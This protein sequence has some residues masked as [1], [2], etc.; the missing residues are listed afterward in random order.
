MA[1]ENWILMRKTLL[2]DGRVAAMSRAC[3]AGRVTIVGGLFVLWCLAD[4]YA[5][6]SNLIP[7][8]GAAEIDLEVQIEGFAAALPPDWGSAECGGFRLDGYH[9]MNPNTALMRLSNAARQRSFRQRHGVTDPSQQTEDGCSTSVSEKLGGEEKPEPV[10]AASERAIAGTRLDCKQGRDAWARW[11]NYRRETRK[12]PVS[13]T[14]VKGSIE[15]L[16]KLGLAG[17]VAAITW[18]IDNDY[19]AIIEGPKTKAKSKARTERPGKYEGKDS[20]RDCGMELSLV[21]TKAAVPGNDLSTR[22]A[23]A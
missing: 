19:Q 4:D 15:R 23:R 7:G 20:A 16:V 18:S 11:L 12:K 3:N 6:D 10:L 22:K 9:R 5:D 17:A 2:R 21:G 1:G 13:A 8:Y 14:A